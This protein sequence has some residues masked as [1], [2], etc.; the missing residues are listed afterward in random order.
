M[1]TA[2]MSGP[3]VAVDFDVENIGRVRLL[4]PVKGALEFAQALIGMALASDGK[5]HDGPGLASQ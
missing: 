1:S 2:T 3:S 5:A 4:M